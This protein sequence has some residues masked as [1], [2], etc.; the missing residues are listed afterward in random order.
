MIGHALGCRTISLITHNKLK[1]FLED[2][3]EY[4]ENNYVD[5]NKDN[6]YDKLVKISEQL[7]FLYKEKY[8][9]T[10]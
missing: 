10:L 5:I 8:L 6:I 3:G 2:I 1:Y 4:K 7:I 9:Q